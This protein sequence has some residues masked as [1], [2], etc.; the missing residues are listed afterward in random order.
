MLQ[1]YVFAHA[2]LLLGYWAPLPF[3]CVTLL[4]FVHFCIFGGIQWPVIKD[5]LEFAIMRPAALLI[6]LTVA[7][8]MV[9]LNLKPEFHFYSHRFVLKCTVVLLLYAGTLVSWQMAPAK[10]WNYIFVSTLPQLILIVYSYLGIEHA[11]TWD[12]GSRA[13]FVPHYHYAVLWLFLSVIFICGQLARP[14]LPTYLWTF[15]FGGVGLLWIALHVLF[16]DRAM[17]SSVT[18]RAIVVVKSSGGDLLDPRWSE[19]DAPLTA[20][21]PVP[22]RSNPVLIGSK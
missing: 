2:G 14:D 13:Q 20:T 19:A 1:A 16:F 9:K 22:A 11:Q 4:A 8:L 3:H 10:F 15:S 18:A 7:R 6:G 5:S 12:L 21:E 17:P